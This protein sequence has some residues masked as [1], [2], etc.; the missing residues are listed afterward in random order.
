M[1][2]AYYFILLEWVL[3]LVVDLSD[4]SVVSLF[5]CCYFILAFCWL[6]LVVVILAYLSFI[7]FCYNTVLGMWWVLFMY[8]WW[9][10]DKILHFGFQFSCV[11]R[12]VLRFLE[13]WYRKPRS[14]FRPF[15]IFVAVPGICGVDIIYSCG[16]GGDVLWC[17]AI[18]YV[19]C[20]SLVSCC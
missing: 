18:H 1:L 13:V 15:S 12:G 4:A 19:V 14:N 8:L 2:F 6:C 11:G 16:L 10:I 5:A 17:V 20:W 7:M 3:L 9:I